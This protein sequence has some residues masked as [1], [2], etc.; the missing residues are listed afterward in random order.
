MT[1]KAFDFVM[2]AHGWNHFERKLIIAW[3][4]IYPLSE[5]ARDASHILTQRFSLG[6]DEHKRKRLEA[7][8]FALFTALWWPD[9]RSLAQA[10]ILAYLVIWLFTWDDEIDEPAGSY[11]DDETKAQAY[12][13]HTLH[14][15][16]TCLGLTSASEP[17]LVMSNRIVESF[18]VIG[19]AL[20]ASYNTHQRQR[21]FDEIVRFMSASEV[22]QACRLQ[23]RIFTLREYW[24]VRMGTSAVYIGSAAGEFSMSSGSPLPLEVMRSS[25]MQALWDETNII[26]SITNDLLSL[27][28]EMKLG[29]I[30]SIIPLTFALTRD[31]QTAVDQSVAALKAS[32]ERFDEAARKLLSGDNSCI[33]ANPE[34]KSQL[35]EFIQVQRSN[36]VGNLIWR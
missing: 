25:E 2:P 13:T 26:I 19:S 4:G 31:I 11:T 6:F 16:G 14:F 29:C 9:A 34:I 5:H 15:V 8:D 32:K 22:E 7:A 23:D 12:R 24:S 36:C 28:K 1:G 35:A 20:C 27:R 18:D 33:K 3:L 10:E 30:D 21:F 17:S